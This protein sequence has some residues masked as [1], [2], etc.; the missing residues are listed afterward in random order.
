L[1][2]KTNSV[3]FQG[4]KISKLGSASTRNC[5]TLHQFMIYQEKKFKK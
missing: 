3:L 2:C 1:A 4:V 5:L